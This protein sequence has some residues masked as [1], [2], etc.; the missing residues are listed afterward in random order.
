MTKQIVTLILTIA[1]F[2][3]FQVHVSANVID[4]D[5]DCIIFPQES[6]LPFNG[7]ESY[8]TKHNTSGSSNSGD[9]STTSNY[10]TVYGFTYTKGSVKYG[11]WRNGVS[12]GS[13]I[14]DITLTFDK[15]YDESY[16]ISFTATVTGEYSWTNKKTIG[17][18]L[19]VTL[20]SSKTYSLASGVS[21]TVPMGK[22]YLVKY[23][24]VYYTYTVVETTYQEAYITGY[25]WHRFVVDE[26][27]CYVDVFSHWDFTVV[28]PSSSS[29]GGGI[30]NG[31]R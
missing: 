26:K 7:A 27:T 1:I 4:P 22:N 25:G 16:N 17:G 8:E 13:D 3:S 23:R 14:A 19:G 2:T 30:G 12:G 15:G 11:S 18:E 9:Y 28:D 10:V 5:I 6:H 21:V 31:G 29:S 24:P 20:G